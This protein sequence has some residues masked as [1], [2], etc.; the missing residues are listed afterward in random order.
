MTFET[1]RS[2]ILVPLDGSTVAEQVLPYA[3]A[4]LPPGGE[5]ILLAVVEELGAGHDVLGQ[6]FVDVED[7]QE[8]LEQLARGHLRRAGSLIQDENHSLRLEVAR[9]DPAAQI[10]QVAT[11]LQV[12]M[13]AMTTRG[14]GAVGR[15]VFGSVA[16]RVARSSPIPVF[17]LR[18]LGAGERLG[19]IRRVVVPLDGSPL[20]LEA[21]PWARVWA[22]RLGVPILLV[23]AVDMMRAVPFELGAVVAFDSAM[24]E[25][26]V[27]QLEAAAISMLEDVSQQ[28]QREGVQSTSQ[29]L[30]G[31]PFHVIADAVGDGDL[32]VMTSHGRSGMRRWLL[33]SVAEKLV[34]EAPVPTILVPVSTRHQGL[35]AEKARLRSSTDVEDSPRSF[36]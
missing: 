33:G 32:I 3:Q 36:S 21:V 1:T 14:H 5:L 35:P 22:E 2:G 30:R 19:S 29:V 11:E 7:L 12:E 16:D 10:V 27:N 17:L 18:A 31:S 24:Y 13:I 34:R 20:A 23:T 25:E 8:S 28:L 9:G 26:L 6:L 15:S 4:L